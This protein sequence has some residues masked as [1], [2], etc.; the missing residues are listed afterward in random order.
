MELETDV[1]IVGAGVAGL[2]AARSLTRFGIRCCV[3]E[4]APVVGGRL[5]T[6]RRPGWEMPIE[7]GAEFVHGRPGPTLALDGGAIHLVAVPEHRVSVDSKVRPLLDT[8][9]RFARALAGARDAPPRESVAQYLA[10]T[11]LNEGDHG[12]VCMLVEGY[13]AAPIADVSAQVVAR[14]AEKVG[15]DFKQYRSVDGYDRVLKSLEHGIA[16]DKCHI[17]LGA[18]VQRVQW[19]PERVTLEGEGHTGSF[20]VRSRR[21]LVSVSLGVLQARDGGGIAFDPTPSEFQRALPLLAM[22]QV[23]RVVLRFESAAWPVTPDGCEASFV[24]VSNTRFT[25]AWREARA[26]QVQITV[27]AGGPRARELSGLDDAT[28]LDEALATVAR[29]TSSSIG[30]CRAQLIEAHHHDFNRDP[31][32]HG[33]YSYVRPSGEH[34]AAELALPWQETLFF[35]GEALD[36]QYPGTVAGALGSGEHVARRLFSTWKR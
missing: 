8:W 6:L 30:T 11:S 26:G 4:A 33:A 2:A 1:A 27:W 25:T 15:E 31:L 18:R 9:P 7:L 10:R 17:E 32:T 23:I 24:H 21:A 20:R 19:G 12:L 22:G 13:H 3:L 14:D 16:A 34:A 28:L 5:R 29:T 36:L 35:A